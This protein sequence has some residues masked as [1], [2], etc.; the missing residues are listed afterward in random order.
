MAKN[1]LKEALDR[2]AKRNEFCEQDYDMSMDEFIC[3]I[4]SL[5]PCKYGSVFAKKV[6]YDSKN[7]M[8]EVP[9][10]MDRG[11]CRI[12]NNKYAE[13]KISYMYKNG[14]YGIRNIRAWQNFDYYILCLV[15]SKFKARYYCL[16]KEVITNNQ[17]IKLN[18]M[19]GTAESNK[20]NDKVGFSTNID[21]TEL[22]WLF[23]YENLLG[24]TSY[25]HLLKFIAS[26]NEGEKVTNVEEI[27]IPS[28]R[29]YRSA[30]ELSFIYKGMEINGATNKEAMFNLVKAI[31]PKKLD[32]VIW[33]SQLSK[34]KK[35]LHEYV[36]GGYYFNPK[37]SLRD[38][39]TT[40]RM[41]N[42]KTN[43]NVQLINKK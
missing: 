25:N 29:K 19:N 5:I 8:V 30:S 21:H 43:L 13:L 2:K 16:N 32:G 42:E 14:K 18:Y 31:G 36:G 40:I 37:F 3:H 24:G 6:C 7:V 23:M 26:M 15:D 17:V 28:N 27:M 11:D 10:K 20:N 35:P 33:K 34:E 39:L 41:I 22:N 38:T 4:S 1:Y 9:N 12:G